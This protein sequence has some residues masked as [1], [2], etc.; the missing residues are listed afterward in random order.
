[1]P[2][3]CSICCDNKINFTNKCNQCKKT[4]CNECFINIISSKPQNIVNIKYV[5]PF[6]NNNNTFNIID[7]ECSIGLENQKQILIK[8]INKQSKEKKELKMMNDHILNEI[9]KLYE[10]KIKT[11]IEL[12]E[13]SNIVKKFK[14]IELIIKK[15]NKSSMLYKNLQYVL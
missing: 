3:N 2:P 13:M 4:I 10:D 1:M 7:P 5:C 6:C 11:E 14:Q 8:V 12:I 9:D 15:S